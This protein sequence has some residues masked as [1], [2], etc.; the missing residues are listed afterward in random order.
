[1]DADPL[2]FASFLAQPLFEVKMRTRGICH[3]EYVHQYSGSGLCHTSQ[4][5]LPEFGTTALTGGGDDTSPNVPG[6][7]DSVTGQS[8]TANSNQVTNQVPTQGNTGALNL[9]ANLGNW[10]VTDAGQ[11]NWGSF[12]LD[13]LYTKQNTEKAAP[14]SANQGQTAQNQVIP[15]N[16]NIYIADASQDLSN[17]GTSTPNDLVNTLPNDNQFISDSVPL[18]LSK[19]F[20]VLLAWKNAYVHSA[21]KLLSHITRK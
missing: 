20:G 9:N 11:G 21:N 12:N 1:M 3:P 18:G 8:L 7:D 13:D 6:Q 2:S 17:P 16:G 14:E 15:S 4:L 19:I 10:L 5:D